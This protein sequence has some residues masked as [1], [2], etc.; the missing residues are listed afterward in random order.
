[1][2]WLLTAHHKHIKCVLHQHALCYVPFC[3]HALS[4]GKKRRFS[5]C[6]LVRLSFKADH[7]I[8]QGFTLSSPANLRTGVITVA[9]DFDFLLST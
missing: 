9:Q 5:P 8:S 4:H 3:C 1:M 6:R 7:Q 2:R